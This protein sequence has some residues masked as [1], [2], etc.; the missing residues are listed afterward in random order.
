MNFEISPMV[1]KVEVYV[2]GRYK[3]NLKHHGVVCFEKCT[4]VM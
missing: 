3:I 4:A 2:C 1:M